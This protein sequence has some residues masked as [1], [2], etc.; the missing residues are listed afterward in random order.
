MNY[1]GIILASHNDTLD[2]YTVPTSPIFKPQMPSPVSLA[3]NI[4]IYDLKGRM[5]PFNGK[6]FDPV[7][8]A[9]AVYLQKKKTDIKAEKAIMII[10]K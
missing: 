8:N 4:W 5:L 3:E 7:A 6:R 9:S 2:M 1:T 10:R